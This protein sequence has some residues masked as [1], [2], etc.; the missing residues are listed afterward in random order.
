MKNLSLGSISIIILVF[1]GTV[2][3][4]GNPVP[5]WYLRDSPVGNPNGIWDDQWS[6]GTV[7]PPGEV[8]TAEPPPDGHPCAESEAEASITP[9]GSSENALLVYTDHVF[10]ND[11]TWLTASMVL[12]LRQTCAEVATV[13]VAVFMVDVDGSNPVYLSGT[14]LAVAAE[15]WPP[16]TF[17]FQILDIPV[18]PLHEARI[19]FV[20]STEDGQCTDLVWDCLEWPTIVVPPAQSVPVALDTWSSVKIRY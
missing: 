7:S 19:L 5:E 11:L 17:E 13:D 3:A 15:A 4:L 2:F 1:L 6:G 16:T 14:S 10:E 8:I 9:V 18:M 20:I 12:S